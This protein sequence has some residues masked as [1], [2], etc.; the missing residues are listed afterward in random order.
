MFS[1]KKIAFVLL[2]SLVSV[3]AISHAEYVPCGFNPAPGMNAYVDDES[4]RLAPDKTGFTVLVKVVSNDGAYSI[5]PFEY[6]LRQ[7][8]VYYR[9][10]GTSYY[11]SNNALMKTDPAD[12]K[13]MGFVPGSLQEAVFKKS[14]DIMQQKKAAGQL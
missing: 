2:L 9:T 12:K 5:A 7:D 10:L 14:F 13:Y 8:G 1:M 3:P 11:A 4:I 6:S